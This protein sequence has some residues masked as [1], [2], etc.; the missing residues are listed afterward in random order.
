M[1][2]K[3]ATFWYLIGADLINSIMTLGYIVSYGLISKQ[4]KGDSVLAFSDK[5]LD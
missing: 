3:A 4:I 2:N 5:R 1:A